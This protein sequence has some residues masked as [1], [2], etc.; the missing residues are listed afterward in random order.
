MLGGRQG[1]PAWPDGG[2]RCAAQGLIDDVAEATSVLA[3]ELGVSVQRGPVDSWTK[4]VSRSVHAETLW[5]VLPAERHAEVLIQKN[6][7]VLWTIVVDDAIDRDGSVA[8]LADSAMVLF[9]GADPRTPAGA[10]LQELL[11][12]AS[13]TSSDEATPL[14]VALGEILAGFHYEHACLLCPAL[15]EPSAYLHHSAATYGLY[16]IL[17]IDVVAARGNLSDAEVSTAVRTY[18]ELSMAMRYASDVGG[19]ERERREGALNLIEIWRRSDRSADDATL[20]ARAERAA[21]S[22]LLRARQI[23]FGVPG[24]A[25][26]VDYIAELVPA[27]LASDLFG[28]VS[29][30]PSAEPR[31]LVTTAAGGNDRC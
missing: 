28:T 20:I 29:P 30:A 2:A 25:R 12:R 27:L 4:L 17:A 8:E 1:H 6:L 18:R 11:R 16:A 7:S 26:V 22:H 19:L 13:A 23:G 9:G 21:R 3:H 31:D 5:P 10:L 15:A 14:R 24:V